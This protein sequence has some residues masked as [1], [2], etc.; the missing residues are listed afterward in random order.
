MITGY[1]QL[2]LVGLP[3]V[4]SAWQLSPAVQAMP[5]S[6]AVPVAFWLQ[7]QIPVAGLHVP[8]PVWHWSA[9]PQV[10]V[11][12]GVQLPLTQRSPSVQALP[13]EHAVP[14][15]A[16]GFEHPVDGLQVPAT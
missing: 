10:T 13:S 16:L 2:E 6:H 14:S 4:P 15:G 5:S 7:E 11:E 3:Q 8:E 12:V 9:A 1:E